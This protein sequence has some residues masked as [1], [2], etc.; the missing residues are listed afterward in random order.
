MLT[1]MGI[2]RVSGEVGSVSLGY[3]PSFISW[4]TSVDVILSFVKKQANFL[5]TYEPEEKR[6]GTI[7]PHKAFHLSI[8]HG[9]GIKMKIT[10]ILGI[11]LH[12]LEI[13]SND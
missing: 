9:F 7:K 8:L 11:T 1:T 12:N 3:V 5:L 2:L 13:I 4:V 6:Q 10:F